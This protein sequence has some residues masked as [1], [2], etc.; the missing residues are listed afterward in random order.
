M[1][2]AVALPF[3]LGALQ[4]CS[5][6]DPIPAPTNVDL[7]I[8]VSSG[9]LS[10]NG[11]YLVKSGL[12]IARTLSGDFLAVSAA[13][14]HEGTTVQYRSAQNNF[15]CPSHGASFSSTGKVTN[16]PARKSLA[17]YNTELSGTTLHVFS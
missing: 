17:V 2:I 12:I 15:T 3:C 7:T 16:G 8:D 9:A 13:C 4:G 1:G 6:N 10:Q 14:T 11:G 5:Q